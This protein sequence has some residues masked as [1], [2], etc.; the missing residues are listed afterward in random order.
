MLCLGLNLGRRLVFG[1][2][3]ICYLFLGG[4]SGGLCVIAAVSALSVPAGQLRLGPS[5]EQRRIMTAT[6]VACAGGLVFSALLLLADAGNVAALKYLL[7]PPRLSYLVAGAWSILAGAI[8]SLALAVLWRAPSSAWGVGVVRIMLLLEGALGVFV[9]LYTGLF[10]A[11]MPAVPLWD[12]PW[13]VALFAASS[14]SCALAAFVALASACGLSA[15]FATW[16]R[17]LVQVDVALIALEAACATGVVLAALRVDAGSQAVAQASALRL[18]TGDLAFVWWVG[19]AL[20]GVLLPIALDL[21]LLR[22]RAPV[23][24]HSLQALAA[25][26]C[27]FVGGVS[28]RYCVVMAGMHPVLGF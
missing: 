16:L 8:L 7:F 15:V 22:K 1:P 6:F 12:T 14:L 4:L 26:L 25:A 11:S 18:L 10:L 5:L 24:P 9:I 17:R 20:A 2:A 13:L 3:V 28:M 23:A 19:F 21:A 27:A